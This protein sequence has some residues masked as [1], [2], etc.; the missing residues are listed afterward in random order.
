MRLSISLL[1]FGLMLAAGPSL[2]QSV[3]DQTE[4]TEAQEPNDQQGADESAPKQAEPVVIPWQAQIYSGAT[5]WRPEEL[6]VREGWDLA[7][8][9]GGTLIASAVRPSRRAHRLRTAGSLPEETA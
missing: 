4:P 9:C 5:D 1:A 2:A 6:A 7:H 3:P 8:K